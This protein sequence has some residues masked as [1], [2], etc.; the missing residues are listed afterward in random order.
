[1]SIDALH[2]EELFGDFSPKQLKA[3]ESFKQDAYQKFSTD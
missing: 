2:C 3:E 1:M